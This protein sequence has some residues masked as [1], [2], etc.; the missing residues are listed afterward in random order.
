MQGTHLRRPHNDCARCLRCFSLGNARHSRAGGNPVQCRGIEPPVTPLDSGFRRND[1]VCAG[2]TMFQSASVATIVAMLASSHADAAHSCNQSPLDSIPEV[3]ILPIQQRLAVVCPS[4]LMLRIL[5]SRL[6][7]A[8]DAMPLWLL[9]V[10]MRIPPHSWKS[11]RDTCPT[12]GRL[13]GMLPMLPPASPTRPQ[14]HW[15]QLRIVVDT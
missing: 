6:R 1:G 4:H 13:R 9:G 5:A 8:V 15:R 7:T 10:N 3:S 11:H 12:C 14:P 2:M